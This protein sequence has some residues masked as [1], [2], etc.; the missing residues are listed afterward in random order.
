VSSPLKPLGCAVSASGGSPA[1]VTVPG[2]GGRLSTT[3]RALAV[4]ALPAT[5]SARATSVC[6]PS[7]SVRVSS[8]TVAGA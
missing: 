6:A 2:R 1:S 4:P 5:S 8:A 7:A 3:T